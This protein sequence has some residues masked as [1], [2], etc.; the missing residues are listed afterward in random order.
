MFRNGRY[1]TIIGFFGK[2]F[3]NHINDFVFVFISLFRAVQFDDYA[4][5]WAIIDLLYQFMAEVP[6]IKTKSN[7]VSMKSI[8]SLALLSITLIVLASCSSTNKLTMGVV[9]PARIYLSDDITKVGIINRSIPSEKN[10]AID[11]IDQI[12]AVPSPHPESSRA[13]RCRR[14]Q[15]PQKLPLRQTD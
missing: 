11:K 2:N 12:H 10:E 1:R 15:S 9:E 4:I 5:S 14:R 8:K 13:G 6:I 7:S 3:Q